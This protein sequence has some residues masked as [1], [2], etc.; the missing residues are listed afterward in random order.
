MPLHASYNALLAGGYTLDGA[1]N[2]KTTG[3]IVAGGVLCRKITPT[4]ITMTSDAATL[5]AAQMLLG[6]LTVD[7]ETDDDILTLPTAAALQ[8]AL[9]SPAVGATFELIIENISSTQG[10]QV[11]LAPSSTVHLHN[12]SGATAQIVIRSGEQAKLLVRK[13]ATTPTFEVILLSASS[14]FSGGEEDRITISAAT[15]AAAHT[16]TADELLGGLILRSGVTAACTDVLPTAALISAGL[17]NPKVGSSFRFTIRHIGAALVGQTNAVTLQANATGV[18]L[19]GFLNS[20][21]VVI[22]PGQTK[23]FLAV[24]TAP[25]TPITGLG[26]TV[27]IYELSR[28]PAAQAKSYSVLAPKGFVATDIVNAHTL[29]AVGDRV[30]DVDTAPAYPRAIRGTLAMSGTHP[31]SIKI[32]GTDAGGNTISE[33]LT[34]TGTN[35]ETQDTAQA[36]AT[37]TGVTS[38]FAVVDTATISLGALGIFGMPLAPGE[39]MVN[40]HKIVINTRVYHA[41]AVDDQTVA[42][43]AV[44]GVNYLTGTVTPTTAMSTS[45]PVVDFTFFYQTV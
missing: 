37:I 38:N 26:A 15:E 33:L 35:A 22:Y 13:N 3:R 34:F 6:F 31:G 42:Q 18:T 40:C 21:S 14:G 8:T 2:L 17:E 23:Q 24:V 4:A 28:T 44:A 1:G 11:S 10:A 7:P 9:G 19:S 16:Y 12:S 5:T 32:D 45:V 41:S 36:F 25:G 43:E 30:V 27:T 20:T 29:V 39:M